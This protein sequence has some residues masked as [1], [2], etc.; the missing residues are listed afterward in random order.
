MPGEIP[1]AETGIAL[2]LAGVLQIEAARPSKRY[3]YYRYRCH[4]GARS[5]KDY[6]VQIWFR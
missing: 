6:K 3:R 2:L 1:V 5:D 4:I